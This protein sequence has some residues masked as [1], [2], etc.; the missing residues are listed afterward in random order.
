LKDKKKILICIDWYAPGF[1]AGGPIRSVANIVN[2]FKHKFDF[3]IL[4]SAYDLGETS[5]YNDRELN[6]WHDQEGV[7]VKYLEK[8][9]MNSSTIASNIR[10]VEPDTI[11]LN[12]LFSKVFTLIPLSVARKKRIKTIIAPRGMLGKGALDIKRSK[13][14]T[15]IKI[16]KSLG[17]FRK[18]IW[19]ASTMEEKLEIEKHFGKKAK[20][21]IA[22]NIP[23]S[24]E[25]DIDNI[26][27]RKNT[28]IVKFVFISRI[29]QK[30][31]LHLAIDSLKRVSSNKKIEFD[32]YGNIEDQEYFNTFKKNIKKHGKINIRYKGVLNPN[33]ISNIY[34]NADFMLLPTMHENYG[35]AIV[36][37]W[38]N[39]CPVIISK[40]TP[41][42][43]LRIKN[44]G[45]DVDIDSKQ[46][47]VNVIQE[48]V[49]IDFTSY[50]Q[51]VRAS[52]NYFGEK[53]CDDTVMQANQK[54]FGNEN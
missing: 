29:A 52:Y 24:Q 49:D 44:L 3:Y 37:A 8:K 17:W 25:L 32:I 28:G 15:F 33:D 23:L 45:W 22:Q 54:L 39:G 26:L 36:E 43:N 34:A 2:A 11:Y 50:I 18:V 10:E 13:K 1:K 51:M 16:A 31:N 6:L 47:L 4:T 30:K 20:I 5:P 40:Y 12:S 53:I 46:N 9:L 48:A 42:K 38:A 14:M 7:F 35:H 41:W 21:E 27:D 19:H